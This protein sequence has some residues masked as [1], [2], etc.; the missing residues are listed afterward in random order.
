[1]ANRTRRQVDLAIRNMKVGVYSLKKVMFDGEASSVN[2][3]TSSGEITV[4]NH[5]QPLIASLEKGVV[6]I[7]DADSQEHFL[8]IS[9]GFLEVNPLNRARLLVDES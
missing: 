2:C 5:H 6:K 7:V 9:A 8:Q 1:M 3:K 4:L